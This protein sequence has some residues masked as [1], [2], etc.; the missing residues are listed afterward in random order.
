M[1]RWLMTK[2]RVNSSKRRSIWRGK[3][4][5]LKSMTISN[6]LEGYLHLLQ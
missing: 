2:G 3:G 1:R 5:K 6:L 4:E